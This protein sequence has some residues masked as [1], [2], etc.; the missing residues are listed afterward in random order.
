MGFCYFHPEAS[1]HVELVLAWSSASM[2]PLE[3]SYTWEIVR[4]EQSRLNRI[5]EIVALSGCLPLETNATLSVLA[6][7]LSLTK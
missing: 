5:G 2:V 6:A 1:W 3:S 7:T 4:A